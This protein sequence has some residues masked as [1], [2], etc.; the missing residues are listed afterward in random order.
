MKHLIVYL[1]VMTTHAIR[2]TACIGLLLTGESVDAQSPNL[3]LQKLNFVAPQSLTSPTTFLGHAPGADFHLENWS[4]ITEYFQKLDTESSRVQVETFGRSTLN[5]PMIMVCVSHERTVKNLGEVQKHQKMLADPRL[6]GDRN[7]EEKLLAESKPVVLITGTIHSSE[8][9]SSLML[10]ELAHEL[11][12][13]NSAWAREV[14]EN[15]VVLI[16]PSVNPDGVDIVADWYRKTLGKP[17]EGSGLPQL[18]H[19]YAGHDTNR[20]FFAN[21]LQETRNI[22]DVL[23]KQWFPTICWDVHQMGS[24]GA[25][26][27]VPP[28]FDPTNPNVDPRITQSIMMIGSHMAADLATE[29]KKGVLHSAMYDNWWN[30]GN[31]TTPQRH[32]MVA[33]LTEAASVRLASPIFFHPSELRASSRGFTSHEPMVNFPD[34]WMGGWWRL[35]D[36]VDYEMIAGRSLL[37]LASRYGRNFQSN[38]LAMGRDQLL[39]GET[40]AP[41]GW[42]VPAG[43][44]DQGRVWDMLDKL[45]RTGIEIHK[46]DKPLAIHGTTYP[47]GTW[48]LPARQPY[49]AHLKD[50][51]ERQ[52]YPNRFTATGQ[53]ETP[54]D[55]AGWTLPLLMGV[56]SVE[57]SDPQFIASHR[58][59]IAERPKTTVVGNLDKASHAII[60]NDTNDD[61]TLIQHLVNKGV[62]VRFYPDEL[63]TSQHRFGPGA[64]VVELNTDARQTITE[65]SPKL[66][67]KIFAI[68]GFKAPNEK[69]YTLQKQRLALYQPWNPSMDEGWT[70]LVLERL[71][72]PYTTV[73]RDDLAAGKLSERFDCILI[74]SIGGQALRTGYKPNE[75]APEFVGGLEGVQEHLK[76]FVNQGGTIVGL[77]DSCEF[78]VKELELPVE[79]AVASLSSK[80]FYGPGSILAGSRQ[81]QKRTR[82]PLSFGVPDQISLYFDRSLAFKSAAKPANIKNVSFDSIYSYAT[83]PKQVLQSGWLLGPEKIAGLS[84]MGECAVGKGHVVLIAFPCQNR[85]QTFGTFRLMVNAIWRGGMTAPNGNSSATPEISRN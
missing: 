58:T 44:A 55:V 72:I 54:Y 69:P 13:G 11:A 1:R 66:A 23:Y 81:S 46:L 65:I 34:P 25:R 67:T 16:M 41:Y 17:W 84:A 10:M 18:Y 20:D 43:Q 51:M 68:E 7:T 53:A 21:N 3:E 52:Q 60:Q 71:G 36:I 31:R 29:G 77:E 33:V 47:A 70:R 28:F 62:P 24:S 27:F 5:R 82:H 83:D 30:G 40:E 19:H 61:L 9:A 49:R 48:Y 73:H 75:T 32:N 6:V 38:Y 22:S 80:D 63:Q 39:K 50:M 57:V 74:P 64:A 14:L 59:T 35:R 78:L 76:A 15:V 37:V 4:K 12:S 79:N 2:L 8:T 56:D 45:A 26:L 42:I 85:A